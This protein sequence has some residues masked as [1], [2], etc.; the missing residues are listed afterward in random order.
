MRF[1]A[2]TMRPKTIEVV[3]TVF[4]VIWEDGHESYYDFETLRRHCPC[5]LCKGEANVMVEYKPPPQRYTPQSF[6]MKRWEYIGGYAIQPHW[7]DGHASGIYSFGYLR[8]LCACDECLAAKKEK[9]S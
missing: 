3:N 6:E 8:G 4:A 7:A 5:A 9:A 2:T 1:A